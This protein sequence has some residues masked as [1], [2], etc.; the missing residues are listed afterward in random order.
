MAHAYNPSTLGGQG[1]WIMRSG[2]Q[3][4][5]GQ[6]GRAQWLLPVIPLLESEGGGS[7]GQEMET[8]LA[9]RLLKIQNISQAWWHV[10]IAPTTREAEAGELLETGRRRRLK[11]NIFRIPTPL[12]ILP[13]TVH[14]SSV[15]PRFIL[16]F[17][18]SH[19]VIYSTLLIIPLPPSVLGHHRIMES[20]SVARLE[21]SGAILAH[22]NLCLLGSEIGSH[23]VAQAGLEL[24]ASN[25]SPASASQ[26]AEIIGVSHQ[27]Q[28]NLFLASDITIP[29]IPENT[30]LK[31]HYG[32]PSQNTIRK[33]RLSLGQC[34]R[35]TGF[36][37]VGQAG[38]KLPT[39]GDSPTLASKVLGLQAWSL[40]VSPRLECS[41]AILA[42]CNLRLPDSKMGFHHVDQ[43]DL[44]LLT[45]SDLPALASQ[46]AGITGRQGSHC[47]TQAGLKRLDSSSPPP[48][49]SRSAEIIGMSHCTQP[50]T[51]LSR[52]FWQQYA[53]CHYV[54]QDRVQ[55][56]VL[57]SL[58]PLSPGFKRF[59][60]L[61]PPGARLECS[62]VI[63]AYCNFYLPGSSSSPA[64]ASPVAGTTGAHH[65][66]QL[67]FV[68]LVETGVLPCW[69]GWSRSVD[70]V[71]CPPRPPKM[72]GLQSLVLLSR[73]ECS[74]AILVHCIL[75]LSG[76]S[77][78]PVS[79]SRVAETTDPCH[80]AQLIFVFLVEMHEPPDQSEK[81]FFA[82][83]APYLFRFTCAAAVAATGVTVLV[84]LVLNSRPQAECRAT[85]N[86]GSLQPLPPS[87]KQFS[88]LSLLSSQDYR[89]TLP[90]LANVCIFSRGGISP[91][92]PGW[93]RTPDL[94][95]SSCVSPKAL[96]LQANRTLGQAHWLMPVIPALWEAKAG[97][98]CQEIE[99]ILANDFGRPKR[100][101]HLRS[102]VRDQ[103]GQH[104]EILSLLKIQKLARGEYQT[105]SSSVTQ[106]GVHWHNLCSL[107]P[108]PPGFKRFSCLSLLTLWEAEVGGSQG[109]EIETN[110]ANMVKPHL[111]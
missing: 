6:H 94:R 53:E 58:Q 15:L 99:T 54:A 41:G 25:D 52:L 24:L 91:C 110:L 10:P 11:L 80:H 56:H 59:F 100:A 86:L 74:G 21:C 83:L 61:S 69:P 70:L 75:R 22:C 1:G 19:T 104:G 46:S 26:N 103:P 7:Q 16:G 14:G 109:Q 88:C 82:L 42:H 37:H 29:P 92:W 102:G 34:L 48:S 98:S 8:S 84:R 49:A 39:S 93:S 63:S 95:H 64:S 55:W 36:H 108:L 38:L 3:D 43:A 97:R 72:L 2:D 30:H 57:G 76:S 12:K 101:D 13:V 50:R 68:F 111:Y 62:G 106:A 73:L 17:S 78:S 40:P 67:I 79:S 44:K 35:P 96:G 71:I 4:H 47:V 28:P 27:T 65:H 85:I 20:H 105:E 18:F 9:N 60:C 66:T 5:P 77:N 45:S 87:F 33:Y 32:A 107:Q 89:Y 23:F 90:C 31:L 51:V 81:G